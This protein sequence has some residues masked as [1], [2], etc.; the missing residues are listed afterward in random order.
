MLDK[1]D[2]ATSLASHPMVLATGSTSATNGGKVAP[3]SNRSG[4]NDNDHKDKTSSKGASLAD[5]S[6]DTEV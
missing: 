2:G 3:T 5:S 4:W 6:S 1:E